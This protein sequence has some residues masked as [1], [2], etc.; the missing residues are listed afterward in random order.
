ML[1]ERKNEESVND[2]TLTVY[3]ADKLSEEWENVSLYL[4]RN[5]TTEN[6][7]DIQRVERPLL[8][9]DVHGNVLEVNLLNELSID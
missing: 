6:C 3:Q 8:K 2:G 5:Y 4:R 7:C 9:S 1:Q